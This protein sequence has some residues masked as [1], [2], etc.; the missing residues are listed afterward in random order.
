MA[1]SMVLIFLLLTLTALG[2]LNFSLAVIV[3]LILTPPTILA[4]PLPQRSVC[5]QYI[6]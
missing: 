2:M 4:Q 6:R 1:K 5:L 3:S